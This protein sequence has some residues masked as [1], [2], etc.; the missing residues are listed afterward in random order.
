[1]ERPRLVLGAL[2]ALAALSVAPA[3]PASADPVLITKITSVADKSR[4]TVNGADS[5][6]MTLQPHSFAQPRAVDEWE[7]TKQADG[8][9]SI[10]STENRQCVTAEGRAGGELRTAACDAA[11]TA[12]H[13]TL[14]R[15]NDGTVVF[16]P[17]TTPRLVVSIPQSPSRSGSLQLTERERITSDS[18]TNPDT[19]ARD[20][21]AFKLDI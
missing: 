1:M 18:S 3:L 16:S 6:V 19:N 9:V 7:I 15:R 4:W 12:Q 21:Q 10:K 14:N 17:K 20:T 11:D 13:W 5:S 8:S 2:G